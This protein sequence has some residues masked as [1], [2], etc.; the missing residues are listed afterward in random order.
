MNRPPLSAFPAPLARFARLFVAAAAL[1]GVWWAGDVVASRRAQAAANL[2]AEE[3][4]AGGGRVSPGEFVALRLLG[5]ARPFFVIY[6][7]LEA[8][9]LYRARQYALLPATFRIISSLQSRNPEV[10]GYIGW[11]YAYNLSQEE[12]ARADR[13]K[14]LRVGLDFYDEQVKRRPAESTLAYERAFTVWHRGS[15][16]PEAMIERYGGEIIR[17]ALFRYRGVCLALKEAADQGQG[18]AGDVLRAFMGDPVDP[19]SAAGLARRLTAAWEHARAFPG[20]ADQPPRDA[21]ARREEAETFFRRYHDALTTGPTWGERCREV[22]AA[23]PAELLAWS[24]D[25]ARAAMPALRAASDLLFAFVEDFDARVAAAAAATP[26]PPGAEAGAAPD[27]EVAAA[28]PARP[29]LRWAVFQQAFL[30]DRALEI[31][32][33]EA[34]CRRIAALPAD[35][36][37]PYDGAL[38]RGLNA[39]FATL[40]PRGAP[41][42]AEARANPRLLADLHALDRGRFLIAALLSEPTLVEARPD[43]ANFGQVRILWERTR[44][45]TPPG[46]TRTVDDLTRRVEM[47]DALQNA[48]ILK[49]RG[50][51]LEALQR[52]AAN[53]PGN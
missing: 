49:R 46:D 26:A 24:E 14:W 20:D 12:T 40:E 42:S 7:W 50:I 2:P 44:E 35:A 23:R 51:E 47:I 45:R 52:R 25:R 43:M 34:V 29:S 9:S 41:P 36:R 3:L 11:N 37:A 6:Y 28:S 53:A 48:A 13:W 32:D 38:A 15:E 10:L 33:A 17:G 18:R 31:A 16:F 30:L 39:A 8:D 27:A 22:L 5:P 4:A 21:P 19:A 1:G